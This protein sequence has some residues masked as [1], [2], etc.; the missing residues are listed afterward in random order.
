MKTLIL[1]TTRAGILFQVLIKNNINI[2]EVHSKERKSPTLCGRENDCV[3]QF[4]NSMLVKHPSHLHFLGHLHLVSLFKV[5]QLRD[6][7]G[8]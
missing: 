4:A 5:L 2:P 8:S 7:L 6:A 3:R 1:L